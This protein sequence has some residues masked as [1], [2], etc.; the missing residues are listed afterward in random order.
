MKN[1]LFKPKNFLFVALIYAISVG[2]IGGSLI[3]FK[4]HADEKAESIAVRSVSSDILASGTVTAQNQA[5][6]HFQAGG[7]LASLPVK[8]GDTVKQGQTIASL[9][10][11][12]LQKQLTSA[13]NTYR[14]TRNSFDQ[15][16]QNQN[17]SVLQVQQSKTTFQDINAG[18][19]YLDDVAKRI[20]DQN[21]ANL[22]NSVIQVELANYAIQLSTLTSPINGIVTHMDVTTPQVNVSPA[23]SFVIQDPS[24]AVFRAYVAESDIDYVSVGSVVTIKLDNEREFAGTVDKVS[25][26]KVTAADGSS[27]YEVDVTSPEMQAQSKIGQSGSVIIKSN[28]QSNVS[29]VPTW[30]VLNNGSVWVLEHGKAVLKP[31]TVGKTHGD[32]REITGG[33]D[34][35]DQVILN[36]ASIAAGKYPLL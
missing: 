25:A 8:E 5:T 30:T 7:K 4:S 35:D 36:P 6:L 16:Q 21:Q 32:M 24:S 3:V 9:D 18:R 20:V 22:D 19:S 14:S 31:V 13:L 10:T 1:K 33:L 23:T 15:S 29:L 17:N 12:T 28:T 11:Y 34:P 27:A 2:I 26:D